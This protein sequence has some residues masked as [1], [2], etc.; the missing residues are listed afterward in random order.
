MSAAAGAVAAERSASWRRSW[1]APAAWGA[2]LILAGMGAAS[3]VT[4]ALDA[5]IAGFAGVSLGVAALIWGGACLARGRIVAPRIAIA[6]MIAALVDLG[7]LLATTGGRASVVAAASAGAL[8]LACAALSGVESRRRAA[9]S[10]VRIVPLL[11]AAT[12]VAALGTPAL[13]AVQD[14]A[15]LRSDGTVPV[16]DPHHGH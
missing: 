15:T 5:R 1:L 10:P 7:A 9:P 8:L 14:A 6:G 3:I 11:L 12:L 16:I 2:G 4:G 13:G